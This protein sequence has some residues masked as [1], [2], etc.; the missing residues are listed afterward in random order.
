MW[1]SVESTSL[2]ALQKHCLEKTPKICDDVHIRR[3][4]YTD[5]ELLI[6]FD[7]FLCFTTILSPFLN[8]G[9]TQYRKYNL[10]LC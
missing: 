9:V 2:L 8:S 3:K 1:T 6:S 7:H 4:R 10:N 5:I